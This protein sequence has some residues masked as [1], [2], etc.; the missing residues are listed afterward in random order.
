MS[1]QKFKQSTCLS[2]LCYDPSQVMKAG[3]MLS[4]QHQLAAFITT[5]NRCLAE[6]HKSNNRMVRRC[7]TLGIYTTLA[8]VRI[9]GAIIT[10]TV[11]T[12]NVPSLLLFLRLAL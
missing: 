12:V 7:W 2:V 10:V 1:L 3:L 4:G 11:T 9:T 5:V 8:P 6:D